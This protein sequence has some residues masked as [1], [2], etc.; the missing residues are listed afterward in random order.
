LFRFGGGASCTDSRRRCITGAFAGFG[1]LVQRFPCRFSGRFAV[2][3]TLP[4][5]RVCYRAPGIAVLQGQVTTVFSRYE[6][7]KVVAGGRIIDAFIH[8]GDLP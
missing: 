2:G 5:G 4:P 1:R 6:I 7:E 8:E 3:D